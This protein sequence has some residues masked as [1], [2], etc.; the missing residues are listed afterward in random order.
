MKQQYNDV[1]M[2]F[3]VFCTYLLIGCVGCFFGINLGIRIA[4]C[5][6]PCAQ[7]CRNTCCFI[8]QTEKER[9]KRRTVIHPIL[10]IDIPT[11]EVTHVDSIPYP[12]SIVSTTAV[13]IV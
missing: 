8:Y 6:T 12:A 5:L 10:I 2:F 13:E 3:I 11:A 1:I 9:M 7:Y 4:I